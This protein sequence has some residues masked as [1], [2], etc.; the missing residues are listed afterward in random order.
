[1]I[2][3]TLVTVVAVLGAA[4]NASTRAA[5]TDQLRADYVVDG[6][7]QLPFNAAEGDELARV[8]GVTA[9]SH[10]RADKALVRGEEI[11]VSGIDPA[12]IARFYRFEWAKGS[13]GAL[14]RLGT[15]GALVTKS[16]ATAQHL[17]V[18]GRL[19]IQSPSGEKRTVVVRG[20]YD[21]PRVRALLYDVSIAQATFDAAF[22]S[23]KNAFTFLDAKPGA[24]KALE[25]AARDSGDAKLHTGRGVREGRH[26]GHGDVPGDALRAAR[27]LGHREPVR[28][29]Q[30][31][32]ALGVRAHA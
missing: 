17:A 28:H 21:P 4:L 7:D 18:G 14:A 8:P 25:A 29:G 2:G 6:N 26:Q 22:P 16:Y 11:D 15:D 31:A 27:V 3:L 9:A 23:P 30:H 1:M 12:T 13:D 10:V 20:I 32:R 19:A 5:V 24:A